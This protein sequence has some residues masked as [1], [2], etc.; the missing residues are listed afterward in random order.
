MEVVWPS[1]A[2]LRGEAPN[3]PQLHWLKI[4]VV[5]VGGKVAARSRQGRGGEMRA[6]AQPPALFTPRELA[7]PPS[8]MRLRRTCGRGRTRSAAPSRGHRGGRMQGKLVVK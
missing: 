1:G 3:H 5:N 4:V 6:G 2:A 8:A 7:S